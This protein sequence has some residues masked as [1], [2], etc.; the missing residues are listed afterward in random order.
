MTNTANT[1]EGG[2]DNA[3]ITTGNSGGGS[4][5]AF[6]F[7]SIVANGSA[8]YENTNPYRG[9]LSGKFSSGVTAGTCYAE[10]TTAVGAASSGSVY[11]RVR[12]R[13]PALPDTTG[14]RVIT[15]SDSASAFRAELRVVNTGAVSI[16][17]SAGT[18]LASF[19]ATYGADE[20][21][22]VALA[23]TV[24]SATI[25]VIE[26]KRY[27]PDGTV[28]ETITSAANQNTLGAGGTNKIAAGMIRSAANYTAYIDDFNASTSAYPAPAV[29][30]VVLKGPWAGGV[31]PTAFTVGYKLGGATTARLVVSTAS[32][33]SSPV[34]GGAV[35][36]DADGLA[37]LSISGLT[38]DTLYYYGVEAQSVLMTPGRGNLTTFPVQDVA[39]NFS[40]AFGSCQF[41]TPSDSTFEEIRTRVGPYGKA[42]QLVHLGD[43]NYLDW[44]G[45]ATEDA[46]IAQHMVSLGSASM[47]PMLAEIPIAYVWDNH[48]WGGDTSNASAAAGDEVGAAY[49]QVFPTYTLPA[50]DGRG[51]F[52]TW[53]IG[54]VRFIM[55]DARS[56][57][58]AQATAESPSKTM[59]GADQKAWLENLLED[60]SAFY[61]LAHQYPWRDDGD[62]SGRWGSYSDEFT[63]IN[64][65]ITANAPGRVYVIF[66]D[67]H[68]LAAD[69]GTNGVGIPHAGGAP[70]QQGS[71]AVVGTWSAG[72]YTI[73]PANL[74]AYGWLDFTDD[75]TDLTIDYKGITSLDD[76][77]RVSMSTLLEAEDEE[78]EP[79]PSLGNLLCAKPLQGETVRVTRLDDCGNPEYGDCAYAVSDGYISITLTPN[80]EEGERFLSR[81]ASGRALINQRSIPSLNWYDVSI[82]FQDIDFE[83]FTI[84]T[85]LEPY[86]DDEGMVIGFPVTESDFATANFSL[87]VWMGNAE[88]SCGEGEVL[89]FYGYNLLPW[90][91]EGALMEDIT[92][93]N[94]V[95]TFTVVGRT[96]KGTPWDVGPYD[97]LRDS[98]GDPAPLPNAIPTDTHHLPIWTQLAP[99]EPECGCTSLSS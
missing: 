41:N 10:W 46:V 48:D 59:L 99:P 37:K 28:A 34:Y 27:A 54:R 74:Q 65:W 79:E 96:R 30:P 60:G 14:I 38:A 51:C 86:L 83:L 94:D 3:T 53:K 55:T 43:M 75:G 68:Y 88:E 77:V 33:L 81:N 2:T 62:G 9:G 24:F 26:G 50:A 21:W 45:T 61:V 13:I 64:G 42:L 97:V 39:A 47:A 71:V 12:F 82:V 95:I 63:E 80:V 89:P 22:D 17:G 78:P 5:T 92:I 4:G 98:A 20:W 90:V 29:A 66:G 87:E 35:V 11:V 16:R 44:D 25:G 49:R 85:G 8:T 76:T 7:V 70:F 32:D 57:R 18:T 1:F 19:A 23:I 15:I 93:A 56:Y 58:D 31:T 69:D 73:A 36:P 40:L 72:S 52:Q 6:D 67:R 91:V 84:V